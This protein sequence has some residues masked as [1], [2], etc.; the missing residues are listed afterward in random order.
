MNVRIYGQTPYQVAVIHGG[1]GAPGSVAAIARELS[2]DLGVLEPLQTRTSLE[3][4]VQELHDTLLAHGT[5]PMTLIGHSWGAWLAWLV[6]ARYPALVAKL[7]L[8]GS[9]PFDASYVQQLSANRLSRLTQRE[10]AEFQGILSQ[11]GASGVADADRLMARLGELV[12][13]TDNYDAEES[14]TER[15]DR[16]PAD[17]AVYES[18]WNEAAELRRTGRLLALASS[19]RCPVLAVHGEYDPHPAAGVEEPLGSVI[20]SFRFEL[21]AKCGHSPWKERHAK[22]RFYA[23]LRSELGQG[24]AV[25]EK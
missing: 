2:K 19:I 15:L 10:Q 23:I 7:I 14:E 21:L 3:G 20:A 24:E 12:A 25:S 4:Q 13:K 11:L 1:P 22:E 18:V 9:G 5:V 17:G 8:V 6:A 16:I